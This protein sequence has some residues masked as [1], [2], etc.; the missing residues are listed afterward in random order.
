MTVD[1]GEAETNSTDT[2]TITVY[3]TGTNDAPV[4]TDSPVAVTYYE[5]I[6]V[7][8]ATG[9]G[10]LTGDEFSGTLDFNDVDV[11]DTQTFSVAS[12]SIL[13]GV[14]GGKDTSDFLGLLDVSA[15][16]SSTGTTTTGTI[17]W[18]FRRRRGLFSITSRAASPSC[19]SM[20]SKWPTARAARRSRPSQ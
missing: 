19:S 14:A 15:S 7:A 8:G 5:A 10:V 1:D 2:N 16:E 4:I 9:Q 12:V 17:G 13:S 3:I 20:W 6:D 18:E 11:S